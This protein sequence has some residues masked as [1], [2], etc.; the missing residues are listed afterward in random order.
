MVNHLYYKPTGTVHFNVKFKSGGLLNRLVANEVSGLRPSEIEWVYNE[1]GEIYS[2]DRATTISEAQRCADELRADLETRGVHPDVLRFC[3]AELVA[4]D[5]FHAVL[6]ATKSIAD[7]IRLKSGLTA[8]GAPLVDA[9]PVRDRAPTGN[10]RPDY[11]KS[12]KRTEGLR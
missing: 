2:V 6:E 9:T 7:K 1:E 4:D 12:T 8:D 10:Q 11:R 5:Y 3:R